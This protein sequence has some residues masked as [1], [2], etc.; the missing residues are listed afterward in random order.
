MPQKGI[1]SIALYAL[2]LLMEASYSGWPCMASAQL[3]AKQMRMLHIN[4]LSETF[5]TWSSKLF[6]FQI[7]MAAK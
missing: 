5:I 4:W 3:V 2:P 7:C 6:S 1:S